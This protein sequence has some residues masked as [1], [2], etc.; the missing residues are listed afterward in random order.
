MAEVASWVPLSINEL[1][2]RQDSLE[3]GDHLV[4]L[5]LDQ[6]PIGLIKV[7]R[8]RDCFFNWLMSRKRTCLFPKQIILLV[9]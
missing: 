6:I 7:A 8:I 9:L 1:K 3:F 2:G 5:D 4:G